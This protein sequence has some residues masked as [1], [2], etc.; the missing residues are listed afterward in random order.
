MA[1]GT[2]SLVWEGWAVAFPPCFPE[3]FPWHP[4]ADLA[5]SVNGDVVWESSSPTQ[6]LLWWGMGGWEEPSPV[7]WEMPPNNVLQDGFQGLP[8]PTHPSLTQERMKMLGTFLSGHCMRSPFSPAFLKSCS[9]GG[10]DQKGDTYP[11]CA[12]SPN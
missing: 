4:D 7:A 10:G 2:M 12:F 6:P 9:S 8:K 5:T 3:R 1:Q 11:F